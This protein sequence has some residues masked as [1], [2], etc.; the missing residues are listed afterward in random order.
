LLF[1]PAALLLVSP[2]I[3]LVGW[4]N[5]NFPLLM[6][7][8][9]RRDAPE[10]LRTIAAIVD[11]GRPLSET[12]AEIAMHHPREDLRRRLSRVACDLGDGEFSWAVLCH[13]RFL[14]RDEA[15]ALDSARANG[16]LAWALRSLADA[17]EARQ[18]MRTAW[19]FEWQRPVLIGVLGALVAFVC[20]GLFLPLA[21]IVEHTAEQ[22]Q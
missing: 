14:R 20:V 7:W 2:L 18:R 17:V 3:S 21:T 16:H 5:L 9:P 4:E 6:R 19:A 11:S 8:F 10:V 1:V 12:L 22:I 13:D 15:A